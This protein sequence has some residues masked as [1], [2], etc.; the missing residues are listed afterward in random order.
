MI[1]Y[2]YSS[3]NNL[4]TNLEVVD[5]NVEWVGYSRACV[6]EVPFLKSIHFNIESKIS[7]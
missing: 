7:R 4:F 2:R 5:V 6:D 1:N 3:T